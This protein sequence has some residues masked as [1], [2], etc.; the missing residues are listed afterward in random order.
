MA[1]KKTGKTKAE[2][3]PQAYN[4]MTEN[5]TPLNVDQGQDKRTIYFTGPGVWNVPQD[6]DE[7]AVLERL[8][9]NS[10]NGYAKRKLPCVVKREGD[11]KWLPDKAAIVAA[12]EEGPTEEE[13]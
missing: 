4:V 9:E 13:R 7:E 6:R 10:G 11:G 8:L 2:W 3:I 5:G 12:L 1:K